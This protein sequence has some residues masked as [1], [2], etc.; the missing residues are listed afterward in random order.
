MSS[1]T[2]DTLK[3]IDRLTESGIPEPQAKAQAVALGEVLQSQELAT[4]ADLRA[5]IT[6]LKSEIIKWVV[7]ISFA[8]LALI[9]TILPQLIA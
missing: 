6:L 7:G 9:L 4:K 2:F 3:Y 1:I 8:Q 5:E